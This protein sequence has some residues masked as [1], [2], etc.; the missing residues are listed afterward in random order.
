MSLSQALCI[1]AGKMVYSI[2][3]RRKIALREILHGT[4]NAQPPEE[5]DVHTHLVISNKG[6]CPR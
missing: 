5:V 1:S 2:K 3:A 6:S 4:K